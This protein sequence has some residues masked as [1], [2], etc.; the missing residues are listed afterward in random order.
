MVGVLLGRDSGELEDRARRL[1][2]VIGG[3]PRSF[4][5]QPPSGWIVGTLADAA[6][7]VA[8]LRDAGVDR[9]MC[10]HLLHDDVD[11][12]E[13]IGRELPGML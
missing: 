2:G 1:T 13:L 3:D 11:A 8:V 10:Q 5:A 12:I 7:Q 6:E 4:L 9:I